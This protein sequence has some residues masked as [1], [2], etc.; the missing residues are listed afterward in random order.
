MLVKANAFTT[1]PPITNINDAIYFLT[2]MITIS[3][4]PTIKI[5]MASFSSLCF[6]VKIFR[7]CDIVT[8]NGSCRAT[9]IT[10]FGTSGF[11][12]GSFLKFLFICLFQPIFMP[13]LLT[14]ISLLYPFVFSMFQFKLLESMYMPMT[15]EKSTFDN[16]WSNTP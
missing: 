1:A 16:A 5:F 10:V 4:A 6:S 8:L 3:P 14:E 12:T 7:F 9:E 15:T 11:T 2:K 13:V